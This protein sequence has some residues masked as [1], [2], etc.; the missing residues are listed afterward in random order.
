MHDAWMCCDCAQWCIAMPCSS[1][2]VRYRYPT[3][4]T[5]WNTDHSKFSPI[6]HAG[7][8]MHN[9]STNQITIFCEMDLCVSIF[10]S[11]TVNMNN[12]HYLLCGLKYYDK[13]PEQH[14][15]HATI[16][17]ILINWNCF[18]FDQTFI[19][20][21]I[22]FWFDWKQQS[23][24]SIVHIND[25][26]Y[27]WFV[28]FCQLIGI[29]EWFTIDDTIIRVELTDSVT[30]EWNSGIFSKPTSHLRS[31]SP[32]RFVLHPFSQLFAC[33]PC[34]K[35]DGQSPESLSAQIV[36]VSARGLKV[37]TEFLIV[38][39]NRSSFKRWCGL[40]EIEMI[41]IV[42]KSWPQPRSKECRLVLSRRCPSGSVILRKKCQYLNGN[43]PVTLF[44]LFSRFNINNCKTISC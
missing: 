5:G 9:A 19:P 1:R 26:P 25:I 35:G 40:I 30:K 11:H 15:L 37:P 44:S 32:A 22:I 14:V 4:T 41:A 33:G 16:S 43:T 42:Q 27:C 8:N 29:S 7:L 38:Q 36:G 3:T 18:V 12:T 2:M 39:A 13:M 24:K 23:F 10:Q 6:L 20:Y 31:V 21:A 34:E 28:G 17:I